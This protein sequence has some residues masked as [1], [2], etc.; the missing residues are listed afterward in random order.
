MEDGKQRQV[1]SSDQMHKYTIP[2]TITVL[3]EKIW[4]LQL[5]ANWIWDL[6][7]E[8]NSIFWLHQPKYKFPFQVIILIY[9]ALE[10]KTTFYC[11][12]SGH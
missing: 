10:Y 5:G 4:E 2:I 8:E 6:Q 1:Q 7:R 11:L 9:S 12:G 3:A